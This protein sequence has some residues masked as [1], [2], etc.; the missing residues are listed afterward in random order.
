MTLEAL[1]RIK[2]E[3]EAINPDYLGKVDVKALITLLIEH[4]NSKMRPFMKCQQF[5]SQFSAAVEESSSELA[6]VASAISTRE[7]PIMMFLK[8]CKA[9][10]KI[11]RSLA[12]WQEKEVK[13]MWSGCDQALGNNL[14]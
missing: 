9:L 6:I 3:I 7:A 12:L 4:F 14:W 10:K 13:R 1:K 2:G 8:E 5:E 11:Q